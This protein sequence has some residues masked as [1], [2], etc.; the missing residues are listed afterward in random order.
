MT[1]VVTAPGVSWA[2]V[3]MLL[4]AK[5][6][7]AAQRKVADAP[8]RPAEAPGAAWGVGLFITRDNPQPRPP[9]PGPARSRCSSLPLLTFYIV[10]DIKSNRMF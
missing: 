2:W 7:T 1:L 6:I 5:Y 4:A 8:R 10:A 9:G 3:A